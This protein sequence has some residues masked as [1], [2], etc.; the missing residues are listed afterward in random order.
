MN[1]DYKR[2]A[3]NGLQ[4]MDVGCSW[5]TLAIIGIRVLTYALFNLADVIRDK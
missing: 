1:T 2:Q 4:Q 3:L 5:R